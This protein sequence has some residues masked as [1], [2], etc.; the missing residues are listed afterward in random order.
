MAVAQI[1]FEIP[2]IIQKGIDD[3][4][5]IRFGGVVRDQAGHIVKHL[6]EVPIPEADGNINQG[7]IMAF[8]KKNKYLLIG[9]V[10]VTAVAAGV[11][12]VVVRNKKNQKVRIP[13]CVADFNE[14]FME[15]VDSIKKGAVSE[16]KI[17]RVMTALEEIKKNQ[18]N[19]NINI[20]FSIENANLLL[21][22]VRNY[23]IKFAEANSF[24]ILE[25]AFDKEN[26]IGSLQRYLKIQ[27]RVFERCA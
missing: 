10:I 15:Y 4:I 26:E 3:G 1:A 23:T 19:G 27:K 18:E 9:T 21:D 5:L 22:M 12:Y 16:E 8:A 25:D 14:S 24:E 17:D 11:T 13:K 2:P 20:T 7:N 6:K